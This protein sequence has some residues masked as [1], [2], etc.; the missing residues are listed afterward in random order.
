MG[1]LFDGCSVILKLDSSSE[2]LRERLI[3]SLEENGA[4]ILEA[5]KN[6][7]PNSNLF[8]I[9]DTFDGPVFQEL[10]KKKK[11]ILGTQC[12]LDSIELNKPLPKEEYP[13]FSRILD[14]VKISCAGTQKAK[15][16]LL[17]QSMGGSYQ[18]E[19]QTDTNY[20]IATDTQSGKYQS[21]VKKRILVLH[22]SWLHACW[23][24]RCFID[25]P[26]FV[27]KPFSGCTISVTGLGTGMR[28]MIQHL[29][30]IYGGKFSPNLNRQCTHLIAHSPDG[31]KYKYARS[32]GI[33]I[34]TIDWLLDSL[35][36]NV[37]AATENYQLNSPSSSPPSPISEYSTTTTPF[38]ENHKRPFERTFS[39]PSFSSLLKSQK[40]FSMKELNFSP[41]GLNFV[42][43]DLE[44]LIEAI[45]SLTERFFTVEN[46]CDLLA[47]A[48][49]TQINLRN[50]CINIILENFSVIQSTSA[51]ARLSEDLKKEIED[52][53]VSSSPKRRRLE[54]SESTSNNSPTA[55]EQEDTNNDDQ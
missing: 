32:W 31:F 35:K 13:I 42:S 11:Y 8:Y 48:T 2:N 39:S 51:Y 17:V 38:N 3:S 9:L 7:P 45:D 5:E 22:P 47:K 55:T 54:I 26:N 24:A 1:K 40:S 15:V 19:L 4:S 41:Y 10:K 25:T 43:E 6:L 14:G 30:N 50:S 44:K 53:F 21:A 52:A 34:I 23:K 33:P 29:V 49:P 16:M 20:L 28:N 46:A 12:I 27:L 18:S 37:C 36:M